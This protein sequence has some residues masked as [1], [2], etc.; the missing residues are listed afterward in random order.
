MMIFDEEIIYLI[1]SDIFQQSPDK[2][3]RL[4]QR[5]CTLHLQDGLLVPPPTPSHPS[6]VHYLIVC[7][8]F[9]VLGQ[10]EH[11]DFYLSLHLGSGYVYGASLQFLKSS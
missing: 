4:C 5:R 1:E 11:E 3:Q 2:W 7:Y 9:V 8:P 6:I 10:T